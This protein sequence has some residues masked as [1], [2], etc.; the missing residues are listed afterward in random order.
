MQCVSRSGNR[1]CWEKG[2]KTDTGSGIGSQMLKAG[3]WTDRLL[4]RKVL[5]C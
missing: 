2:S 4:C 5:I 1:N 3:G